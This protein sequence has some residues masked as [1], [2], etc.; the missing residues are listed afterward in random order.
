M[1][2]VGGSMLWIVIRRYT[3]EFARARRTP[4]V[5]PGPDEGQAWPHGLRETVPQAGSMLSASLV[6]EPVLVETEDQL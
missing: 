4:H 1:A 6:P 2:L 5:E 3:R